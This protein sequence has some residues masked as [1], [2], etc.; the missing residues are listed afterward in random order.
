MN[1]GRE[2]VADP[3][4]IDV[5]GPGFV[6]VLFLQGQSANIVRKNLGARDLLHSRSS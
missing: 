2:F 3:S 1:Q 5:G 4:G 6:S